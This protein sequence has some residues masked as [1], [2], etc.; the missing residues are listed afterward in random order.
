MR[1]YDIKIKLY[2][3]R[4]IPLRQ[5]QSSVTSFLDKG[6]ARD[7]E[8]LQMHKSNSYKNYCYDNPHKIDADKIYH[9]GKIYTLTVR[10]IDPKEACKIFFRSMCK[11][12]H[13]RY[14]RADGRNENSPA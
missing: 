13:G 8:L 7:T 6:F 3:L 1:V 11:L 10:T 12:L 9:K 14:K 2:V 5:I 4:D